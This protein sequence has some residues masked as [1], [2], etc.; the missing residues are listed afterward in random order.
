[1]P[2][3]P[4]PKPPHLK[5][6]EGNPGKRPINTAAPKPAPTAPKAPNWRRV[7]PGDSADIDHVRRDA[8]AEW[9]RVVPV[10]DGLGLLS[11]VD[12]TV[13]VDY[14][15]TWARILQCER[16]LSLEGL[17]KDTDRG[18]AKNPVTTI[19]GQYRSALRNYTAELGLGPSSR[20]RLAVPGSESDHDHLFGI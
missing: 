13:L 17:T 16:Q 5:L 10:L 9:K 11:I 18:P 20:G 12:N 3:G 2:P 7:L 6:I 4:K 1:M 8:A 14:C 19:V 15:I